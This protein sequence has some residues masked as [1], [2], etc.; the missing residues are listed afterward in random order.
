MTANP[1][2]L[3]RR[4]GYVGSPICSS[5][6]TIIQEHFD[7]LELTIS[8]DAMDKGH[9][10]RRRNLRRP[11]LEDSLRDPVPFARAV[12]ERRGQARGERAVDRALTDSAGTMEEQQLDHAT[13]PP[14]RGDV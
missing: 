3:N 12:D 5:A 8:H 2:P 7:G 14:R 9:T 10:E 4:T 6:A 13:G 1:N 11:L